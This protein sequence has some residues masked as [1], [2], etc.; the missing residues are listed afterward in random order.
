MPNTT[1][2]WWILASDVCNGNVF[3]LENPPAGYSKTYIGFATLAEGQAYVKAHCS[4]SGSG[5]GSGG[6]GGCPSFAQELAAVKANKVTQDQMNAYINGP[7]G[8][9]LTTAQTNQLFTAWRQSPQSGGTGPGLSLPNPLSGLESVS[10]FFSTLTQANTW[11]RVAEV[12]LGAALLIIGLAKL[13]SGTEVG[14]AAK[15][16]AMKAALL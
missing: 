9:K 10:G 14:K 1:G 4:G 3:Q 16:I 8:A 7:C 2:P 13:A 5:S 6:G 12:L 11:I 15:G